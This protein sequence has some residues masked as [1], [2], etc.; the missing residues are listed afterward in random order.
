[1]VFDTQALNKQRQ[2]LTDFDDIW[3]FGYGSLI[4]KVDFDHIACENAHIHGFERRF[5]QGSH[6][7]R[8]TPEKPGRV[9]TLTPVEGATCFGKAFKVEHQVFDHLDHR[10]K[11]GYLRHS[12]D[13]HLSSNRIVQGLVYI[14]S[15]DNAAY[16]GH[17]SIED[18]AKQIL[19]SSGPSGENKDYLFQ[20]ADAL[21]ANNEVDEHVFAIE[22]ALYARYSNS[23]QVNNT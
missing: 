20:L 21:R 14:A 18:I 2:N 9:L 11:N 5:W 3:V 6:D 19:N 8:G 15:P 1:M 12:I 4:Y 13:I 17:A 10:E 22:K 23:P 16:L 7:H